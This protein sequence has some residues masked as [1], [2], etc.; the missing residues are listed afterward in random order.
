MVVFFP[1][2]LSGRCRGDSGSLVGRFMLTKTAGCCTFFEKI[3]HVE[4]ISVMLLYGGGF[5][6]NITAITIEPSCYIMLHYN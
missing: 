6:Y 5:I 4:N 1:L 2:H 3:F